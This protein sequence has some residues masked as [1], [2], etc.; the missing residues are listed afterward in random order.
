MAADIEIELLVVRQDLVRGEAHLLQAIAGL[1][2][3]FVRAADERDGR[4]QIR[5]HMIQ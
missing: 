2:D 4:S 1:R 5:Q 3:H